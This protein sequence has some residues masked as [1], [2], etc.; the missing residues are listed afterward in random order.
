MYR[1]DKELL[2]L[3]GASE[4]KGRENKQVAFLWVIV[5]FTKT[6][7]RSRYK[8]PRDEGWVNHDP[9]SILSLLYGNELLQLTLNLQPGAPTSLLHFTTVSRIGAI[10]KLFLSYGVALPLGVVAQELQFI[11]LSQYQNRDYL[12]HT[13]SLQDCIVSDDISVLMCSTSFERNFYLLS[14]KIKIPF[15]LFKYAKI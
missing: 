9:E 1:L 6:E 14:T 15:Y 7:L 10:R 8:N 11:L 5:L 12:P 13:I 3:T 4:G 2:R